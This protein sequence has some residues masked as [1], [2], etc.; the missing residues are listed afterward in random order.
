MTEQE[1]QLFENLFAR[2]E[3]CEKINRTLIDSIR[4]LADSRNLLEQDLEHYIDNCKYEIMDSRYNS[5][6]EEIPYIY[7]I[8]ETVDAIVN[9]KKSICRFGDGEFACISGNLRAKFTRRYSKK[10]ADRLIEVLNSN[11]EDILIALA[12][13]YGNLDRYSPQTRREIRY[14]MTPEVRREHM[15]LLS[16]GRKYYNAYITRPYVLYADDSEKALNRFNQLKKIWNGKNVVIIEGSSTGMGVGNDLLNNCKTI[17]RIIA[18]SEDAFFCY[19]AIMDNAL[20]I[21]KES[22]ILIALGPVAT[23]LAYDL[24]KSGYQ[25]IDIGHIDLEY[26]W[27]KR[28]EGRRTPVENKYN[29]EYE[30]GDNPTKISDDVYESQILCRIS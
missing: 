14:Y 13:N 20:K 9:G 19:E 7:S 16:I 21:D 1:L 15:N 10:L 25:A 3:E 24:A 4:V 28:G 26:E 12:D 11:E 27:L 2:I 29:N 8:D 17:R 18:P 5:L 6:E 22:L 23:V 30:G